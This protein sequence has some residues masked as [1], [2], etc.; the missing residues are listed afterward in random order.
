MADKDVVAE[1]DR[2]L[3]TWT[4][5]HADAP[6]I[7]RARD[8]IV[9]LKRECAALAAVCEEREDTRHS[10]WRARQARTE[11]LEEAAQRLASL[12]NSDPSLSEWGML[13][14]LRCIEIIRAMKDRP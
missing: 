5:D 3:T 12:Y 4:R 2:W 6:L 10:L 8:E 13:P 9:A 11:A 14:V 7:R 1:L